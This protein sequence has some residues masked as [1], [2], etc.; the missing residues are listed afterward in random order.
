VEDV[1]PQGNIDGSGR[2]HEPNR[3][4]VRGIIIFTILLFVTGIAVEGVLGLTMRHFAQKDQRLDSLYPGR[5][6]LDVDQF[7]NPRLQEHPAVE[8]ARMRA[9]EE[10]RVNAYG[11]VDR[12]AGI[13]HIPVERAMD[14]LAKT[15]LP[16][17][18]A[19]PPVAGVPPRTF[20]PPGT[21]REEPKPE[22]EPLQPK[23]GPKS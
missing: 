14:I 13:A 18:P 4:G 2:G 17:V 16:K 15:G 10:R 3:V 5:V 23:R 22:R 8:L 19:P 21:K 1:R 6:A 11:W 7:P 12:K 20:I 9:D